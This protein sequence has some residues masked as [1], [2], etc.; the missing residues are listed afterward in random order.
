MKIVNG[1]CLALLSLIVSCDY[2]GRFRPFLVIGEPRVMGIELFLSTS[3]I[4]EQET[5]QARVYAILDN[6]RKQEARS[7][8]WA[9]MN[10]DVLSIDQGGVITGLK[11]GI[12]T[13]CVASEGLEAS[14]SVEVRRR[15]DYSRIMISEV[16][17]DAVGADDGKEFIELYNDNDY[18]CDIGG[19]TV[20]DGAASSKAFV[21]P[22]ESVIGPK[23]RAVIAQS[24]EGFTA[25]FG[26]GPDYAH[27]TFSL[28]NSGEAV[29]LTLPDGTVTD[30]V[31]IKGGTEDFRPPPS[32][33]PPG[34]P[35]APAGQSV[36]RID[37]TGISS[38]EKWSTGAPTPGFP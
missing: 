7:A 28:N 2:P 21:L 22:P 26:T 12:G 23:S 27:F 1:V 14:G 37:F 34:F 19:M 6:G 20:A 35:D 33:G 9:T 36:F 29:L 5:L 15:N 11:P 4:L 31:F 38:S 17:Y 3:S 24:I 16:F 13:I 30:S 32:W 18:P 25:A 8:A 10:G